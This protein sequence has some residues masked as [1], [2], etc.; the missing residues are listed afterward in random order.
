MSRDFSEL[1]AAVIACTDPDHGVAVL[2]V[3]VERLRRIEE[4]ARKAIEPREGP[5]IDL[6][7]L[8]AAINQLPPKETT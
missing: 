4:A 5:G 7:D 8:A 1:A 2:L 6:R 3:E